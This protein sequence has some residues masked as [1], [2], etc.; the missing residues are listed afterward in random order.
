MEQTMLS[1]FISNIHLDSCLMNAAGCWCYS[2][3]E[4]DQLNRSA[5]GAVVSKSGTINPRI[6]NP[7]P[8]FHCNQYGSINSM[9]IPN[10][11][12][13]FYSDYGKTINKPF[14]QSIYPFS[15]NDLSMMLYDINA[16]LDK[17]RLI[18]VNISCPNVNNFIDIEN[19]LDT[20]NQTRYDQ[21]LIG[22]KLKPYYENQHFDVVANLLKKYSNQIKFITCINSIV[23]GMIIDHMSEKP[24]IVPNN[25]LG[26]IGGM[27]CKPIALSNVYN[28]YQRIPRD[29]SIIGCGGITCGIDAFEH[30]LCGASAIQIGT[31]L[32]TEGPI[33]FD[34]VGNELINLMET[35]K[36]QSITDFKGHLKN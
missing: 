15:T 26:G 24:V 14:I 3:E 7:E 29:I 27:Y 30:I 35:K 10:L 16:I 20:I 12:Y 1:T 36:Y 11:G 23:N 25:G 5:T 8:R 19:W 34:R 9:G 18:E 33:V 28:F 13:Q 2:K 17:R 21:L 6:G 4:L 32:I 31:Q 22:I